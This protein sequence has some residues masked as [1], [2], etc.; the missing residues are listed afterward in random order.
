MQVVSIL[1]V[2]HE[3]GAAR[4]S[5]EME[6]PSTSPH[7]EGIT[8]KKNNNHNIIANNAYNTKH[9]FKLLHIVCANPGNKAMLNISLRLRIHRTQKMCAC[10]VLFEHTTFRAR[11]RANC[12]TSTCRERRKRQRHGAREGE[13]EYGYGS[14]SLRFP[15]RVNII[16]SYSPATTERR[17]DGVEYGLCMCCVLI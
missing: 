8:N 3:F 12:C 10:Y 4:V 16:L 5:S 1:K 6:H 7:D 13:G 15:H 17:S 2:H 11:G 9:Y 14:S